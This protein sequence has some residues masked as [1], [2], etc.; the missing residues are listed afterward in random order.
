[1]GRRDLQTAPDGGT[2]AYAVNEDGVSR[3]YLCDTES[4]AVRPV[5]AVPHGVISDIKWH[6]NSNDVAFNLRSPRAPLDVYVLDSQ[7][8]TVER[9]ARSVRA[10]ANPDELV[11]PELIRWRSFDGLTFR[12]SF[13]ARRRNHRQSRYDRHTAA[14]EQYR[15]VQLH[16]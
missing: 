2:I 4:G 14:D 10:Q 8:G 12:D 6:A 16:S 11:E 15:R 9:W 7:A 1:M 13:T 3:L 5:P